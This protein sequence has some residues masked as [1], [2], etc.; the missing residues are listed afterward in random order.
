VHPD[1]RLPV[2]GGLEQQRAT[3]VPG[4]PVEVPE[5]G[6][7][8]LEVPDAGTGDADVGVA[9]LGG[10]RGADVVA[11]D[12]ADP[13]VDDE[14]LSVVASVAPDVEEAPARAVDGVGLLP[15]RMT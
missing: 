11:A 8:A 7:G 4:A 1:P 2:R 6:E 5:V 14:D 10:V 9:P 3:A 13:V 15:E 12:E